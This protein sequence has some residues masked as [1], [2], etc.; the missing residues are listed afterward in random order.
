MTL[1]GLP[2]GLEAVWVPGTL[3]VGGVT[4]ESVTVNVFGGE[5]FPEVSCA[6]QVTVVAP[7]G[8]VAPEAG[9]Q[10]P[11]PPLKVTV[12]VSAFVL[13]PFS[14]VSL[15]LP[16]V[17]IVG[18]VVSR[19]ST[20]NEPVEL[21]PALSAAV[22]LT[23]VVP[24]VNVEPDGGVHENDATPCGSE[25]LALYDTLAL[26]GFVGLLDEGGRR[27]REARAGCVDRPARRVLALSVGLALV[28]R[29]TNECEPSP[30]EN[31]TPELQPEKPLPST[32]HSTAASGIIRGDGERE[33]GTGRVGESVWP[34]RDRDR[35]RICV[36]KRCDDERDRGAEDHNREELD[37]AHGITFPSIGIISPQR[38]PMPTAA[39]A[40]RP[41]TRYQPTA[42]RSS[43]RCGTKASSIANPATTMSGII[44]GWIPEGVA[45]V[46]EGGTTPADVSGD[47]DIRGRRRFDDNDRLGVGAPGFTWAI[48]WFGA[49]G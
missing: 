40:M 8:N 46:I 43:N 33:R 29:T 48:A 11:V 28:A 26:V 14:E 15:M 25:A 9:E 34:A 47:R 44:Q 27:Q 49:A 13:I 5:W 2:S 17:V 38:S 1:T 22:Q 39:N 3:T 35:R 37:P 7:N 36:R 42:P 12:Y 24:S 21:L 16:G 18:G 10:L 23:V 6:L 30:T 41:R 19:T 20:W 4:S 32:L 45:A 31:E